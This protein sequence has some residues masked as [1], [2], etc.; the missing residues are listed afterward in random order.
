[1]CKEHAQKWRI[2]IYLQEYVPPV[3]RIRN[4]PQKRRK[5]VEWDELGKAVAF[6]LTIVI[7]LQGVTTINSYE[8]MREWGNA[9]GT[10][11][12]QAKELK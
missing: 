5:G 12:I 1:M 7:L 8:K 11:W 9:W 4:I 2:M 6:L 3:R 10:A